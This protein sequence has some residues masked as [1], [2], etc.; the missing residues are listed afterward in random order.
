[1][2]K[3]KKYKRI[4]KKILDLCVRY[5]IPI[6]AI[7]PSLWNEV[8][9]YTDPLVIRINVGQDTDV[10]H[11][12]RH[13]FGHYMCG[14]AFISDTSDTIADQIASWIEQEEYIKEL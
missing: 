12:A 14:H 1:M 2:S 13:L 8:Y 6:P 5:G 7:G 3:E 9:D 11:H 10:D 4:K